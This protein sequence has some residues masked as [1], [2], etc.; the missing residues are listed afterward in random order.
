M[1]SSRP[2]LQSSRQRA[3]MFSVA[4]VRWQARRRHPLGL[5]ALCSVTL[6]A[7]QIKPVQYAGTPAPQPRCSQIMSRIA[8]EAPSALQMAD[9]AANDAETLTRAILGSY[10]NA[11][12]GQSSL[13]GQ[14]QASDRGPVSASM[15]FLSGGSQNGA[16]GAGFLDQW[17][18]VRAGAGRP[19][20]LPRFRVVTGISTGALQSTL[21]FLGDTDAI[22]RS[23][24]I[25]SEGELLHPL[26]RRGLK[27]GSTLEKAGAALTVMRRG[28]VAELE[29]LRRTLHRQIDRP[30]LEAVAREAAAG[31]FLLVG[32]VEMDS[33]DAFVFDL[34]DAA[35]R[36]VA[37]D[38]SMRDCYIEALMASSSV[39]MAALP[40]FIDGKMFIDGGARFGV[41]SDH[42]AALFEAA[43]K[44]V[45][46]DAQKNLFIIVNGTLEAGRVCN[47]KDCGAH[48]IP[49]T[50][51]GMVPLHAKWSFDSL[52]F[53]SMSILINQSYR[54]SVYWSTSMASQ[55]GFKP[56]FVRIEDDLQRHRA[57]VGL[58]PRP[59]ESQTCA[60][61]K[62]LDEQ[63]DAPL[64]FH[65]RFMRC[66]IDY[67]RV[68]PEVRQW[69]ALE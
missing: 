54:S 35:T 22:V 13:E 36:F 12:R 61:W 39:P 5:L 57:A 4:L 69:A 62:A 6:S 11:A 60:Y 50:P 49:A 2:S 42:T 32:A 7:C 65:P 21:A 44:L 51:D 19:G 48:P 68:R 63:R 31:R 24:S 64:E 25:Q 66:E 59:S 20:G 58:G 1:S 41:L 38:A 46:V 55:R 47:L 23:Y 15:L 29:P 17:A 37:G 52:A 8:I 40:V 27:G 3:G 56:H 34:T 26:T 28:A 45:P 53:R 10:R 16:F 30:R 18:D 67:G 14:S 43:A 33:G 9:T